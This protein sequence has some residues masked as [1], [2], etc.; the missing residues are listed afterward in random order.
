MFWNYIFIRRSFHFFSSAKWTILILPCI[1]EAKL[2][3]IILFVG[4]KVESNLAPQ[5]DSNTI[6][7]IKSLLQITCTYC[8]IINN[9]SINK[10]TEFHENSI[11]RSVVGE[12]QN[13][14]PIGENEY[15]HFKSFFEILSA[16][17]VYH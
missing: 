11:K 14:R 15:P 5:S 7:W 17:G 8:Q 2:V 9:K 16:F 1:S 13:F 3:E 4:F 12:K 6:K 10:S